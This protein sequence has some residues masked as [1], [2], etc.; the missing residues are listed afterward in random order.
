LDPIEFRKRNDPKTPRHR[1]YDMAAEII[2]WNQRKPDGA[3][4]GVIKRGFGC[5]AAEWDMKM[6]APAG[7]EVKIYRDGKVEARSGTQDMGTGNRTML[8]DLVAHGMGLNRKFIE[9]F[10]G[11][12]NY[13][14][15]PAAGGSV[16]AKSLAPAALHAAEL[17]RNEILAL[18]AAEL[19]TTAETLT[20][21]GDVIA[22][23][24]DGAPRMSWTEA[25]KLIVQ[26]PVTVLGSSSEQRFRGEGDSDGVCL[27][28]V[29]VDTETGV[30]RVLKLVV[31]QMCGL[32]VNRKVVESQ[33]V[34]GAIQGLSYTLHENRIICE[35]NGA[36][37]NPNMEWYKIS[38]PADMPE[39]IPV[40]DAPEGMNTGVR[41]LGEPPI[42][43]VPG[44]IANAVANAIGAR[45][46]SLPIT[47]EKVLAALAEK[48][49]AAA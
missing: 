4:P 46:R 1:E 26:E 35:A 40:I 30:V 29:E 28:E 24:A 34:G 11:S 37:C 18:A 17:A 8:V 25:C 2:G 41:S 45:V 20:I 32:P 12:S 31:V 15:G 42:I 27:A 39:I 23:A 43:G 5:G 19:K 10:N 6:F 3:S 21:K 33:I 13:P 38:G 49:G 16:G 9:G 14:P 48:K 47:P 36:H 44:A 22:N 7:A